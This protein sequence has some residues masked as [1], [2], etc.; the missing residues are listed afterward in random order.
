MTLT[1]TSPITMM[2]SN[3]PRPSVSTNRPLKTGESKW[4]RDVYHAALTEDKS[5]TLCGV[6]SSEWL[7]IKEG[8]VEYALN[9]SHFCTRC[10]TKLMDIPT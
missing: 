7:V 3:K 6:D 4:G 10:R 2:C 8:D 1:V 9:D 5:R